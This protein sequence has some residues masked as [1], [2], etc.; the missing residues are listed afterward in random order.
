MAGAL[1]LA[2][3]P[4]RPPLCPSLEYGRSAPP[5]R[6]N[7]SRARTTQRPRYRLHARIDTNQILPLYFLPATGTRLAPIPAIG[8]FHFL[9]VSPPHL[10]SVD[11]PGALSEGDE[12]TGIFGNGSIEG[13]GGNRDAG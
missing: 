12:P 6:T 10:G 13:C 3:P 9:L 1:T 5:K 2:S 4:W 7:Q 11:Y 8:A